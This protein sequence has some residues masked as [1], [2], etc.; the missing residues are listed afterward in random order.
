ME[1]E[2]NVASCLVG[3]PSSSSLR[4]CLS[5]SELAIK[6]ASKS[7][8]VTSLQD[9]NIEKWKLGLL[10]LRSAALKRGSDD[11]VSVLLSVSMCDIMS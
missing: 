7:S 9:I 5:L 4:S 10:F 1:A 2:P 3:N 6:A 11:F 8:P